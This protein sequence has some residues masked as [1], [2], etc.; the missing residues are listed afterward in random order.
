MGKWWHI[1]DVEL[2]ST[3]QI[4]KPNQRNNGWIFI[5]SA[6]RSPS[7]YYH[8]RY[9]IEDS[10]ASNRWKKHTW[11]VW[12][13]TLGDCEFCPELLP[14][15]VFALILAYIS[16]LQSNWK[17]ACK[18][19]NGAKRILWNYNGNCPRKSALS[20]ALTGTKASGSIIPAPVS[21][22][23]SFAKQFLWTKCQPP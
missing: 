12:R 10:Q 14:T 16:S 17:R 19:S 15:I 21:V 5:I 6:T 4:A 8:S 23:F 1:D 18:K 20:T 13:E 11:E 9:W 22:F 3:N 7:A 2:K